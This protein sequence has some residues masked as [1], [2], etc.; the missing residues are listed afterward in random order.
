MVFS[1]G[2][3]MH[4][5]GIRVGYCVAPAELTRELRKVHQFNTFSIAHAPQ[6]AIARYLA[7]KPD[8]WRDVA[9]VLSGQARPGARRAGKAPAS[10]CRR[11]RGLISNSWTSAHSRPADDLAFAER[12]LTEA[13]VATIPLSPFYAA[14]PALP[15]LRLCIAKQDS[16]LDE[17]AQRLNEFAARLS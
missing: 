12:L 13:G 8:S 16:T 15:V 9:A 10:R 3:T 7:E 5:T 2:K 17:A 4:A 11:P 14:P 6:V 1:F